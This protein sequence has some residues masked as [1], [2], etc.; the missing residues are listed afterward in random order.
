[1]SSP[2][3][4]QSIGTCKHLQPFLEEALSRGVS[5][6]NIEQGYSEVRQIVRLSKPIVIPESLPEYIEPFESHDTH[7]HPEPEA[8]LVCRNC[9]Q[10]L[11]WNR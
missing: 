4:A 7:Y 10:V 8:G 1:M 5:I 2:V 6:K 9:R 11:A 3:D